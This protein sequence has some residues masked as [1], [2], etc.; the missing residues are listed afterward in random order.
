MP[1]TNSEQIANDYLELAATLKNLPLFMAF[2]TDR[3]RQSGF[4]SKRIAEVELVIEEA[5]VNIIDYA[6]PDRE[7][8]LRL[9]LKTGAEGGLKLEIKDRGVAFNPLEI[10]DPD[11][12]AELMERPVGGLGVFLIKK[13]SDN[14]FWKQQGDEN[15]LTIIF[16]KRHA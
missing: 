4:S 1:S 14:L 7:G 9:N 3:A 8:W 12:R 6:Y 5:L 10:E 15:C 11:L 2:V 16:K 13:F